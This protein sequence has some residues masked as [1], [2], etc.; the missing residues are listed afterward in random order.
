M[1]FSSLKVAL[2]LRKI[3]KVNH[4]FAMC[5]PV[6]ELAF[7]PAAFF[8]KISPLTILEAKIP[9]IRVINYQSPM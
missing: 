6:A 3:A 7:V 2:E 8:V 4:S 9:T 5:L 1:L